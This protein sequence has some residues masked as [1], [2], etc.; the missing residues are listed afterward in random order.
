[1]GGTGDGAG[2]SE[3]GSRGKREARSG[4]RK[5]LVYAISQSQCLGLNKNTS[6]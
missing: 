2:V 1:M 3:R 5:K 6:T 4:E